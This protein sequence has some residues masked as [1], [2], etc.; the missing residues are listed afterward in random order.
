MVITI[1]P[2]NCIQ[3]DNIE[4]MYSTRINSLLPENVNQGLDIIDRV[5]GSIG[6]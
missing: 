3:F 5:F 1:K 2:D 4:E 6:L